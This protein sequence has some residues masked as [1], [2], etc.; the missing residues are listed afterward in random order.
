MC[1]L[2]PE[3]MPSFLSRLR[4]R[5]PA[6][7]ELSVVVVSYN[8]RR[9]IPRTLRSLSVPY[10]KN[11]AS[12][13]YEIV[14]VD[15][16]SEKPWLRADFAGLDVDVRT[17]NLRNATPSP[18]PAVNRGLREA[19][20][21][22]VGVLIDGARMVTPG[23][24]D[25]CR[26]AACLYP[27]PIVATLGFHLGFEHQ[28]TSIPKG[29]SREV[30]DRLLKS[31]GW[32]EDGYRLFEI[33]VLNA[34]CARGWFRPIAE[35][36]V[37][38]M[39]AAMW[40][41]L[42]GYSEAFQLAGG[43]LVNLDLYE[44]ALA[45]PGTQLV[46][47]LGEGNF[48]QVHG[49]VA[50]N[51]SKSG[52]DVWHEEYKRIRGHDYKMPDARAVYFGPVEGAGLG[53]L[54]YSI[55]AARHETGDAA[56]AY[57]ELL[58]MVLLNETN[59]EL[60]LA[61]LAARDRA[62]GGAPYDECELPDVTRL[63]RLREARAEGRLLDGDL[64]NMPQ[65]YTMIGR[66]RMDNV[67]FCV[68]SVLRQGIL[69]DLVECGVWKG[70]ACIFMRG[71]LKASGIGDRTVWVADS[72]CGLPPPAAETDEGL[73]LSRSKFPQLA[74]SLDRVK[75]YFDLFGLL[76]EQVRF[77]PGWFSDTL[78]GAGI[79]RIS[80]LRLDGDLYSSTMDVFRN[81]YDKVS[82]G[83][84]IIVDDYGVLPQCARATDEFRAA[85]GITTP[86]ERID[87]TGVFWRKEF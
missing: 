9:E 57:I 76:D 84:F 11:I 87:I 41:E 72:F 52:W 49:G 6:P 30:E 25:A 36:N 55:R 37:L 53:P 42:G 47:L 54:D 23:V 75:S 13:D 65:G 38:F 26:R 56:P 10:Q 14:L 29:Y 85:R 15:N 74:I 17:V 45:L 70:G 63:Q 16:G 5:Q 43:G 22:L 66:R 20:G 59:L 27:R 86:M 31:I 44:R 24:L 50:S 58:K 35:S 73:D 46:M 2:K 3:S 33:S 19:R 12:K 78:P 40:N 71:I 68:E 77:L 69:G 64:S 1:V 8:M 51:A 39:P 79:Q 67:Q 83:G 61:F 32:P 21:K 81:L 18:A 82:P 48:H 28:S 80:V 60:E 62:R 4:H 34:S 7:P